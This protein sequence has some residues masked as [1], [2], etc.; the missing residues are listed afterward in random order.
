MTKTWYDGKHHGTAVI[1]KPWGAPAS[2]PISPSL[3]PCCPLCM[4]TKT[5][6]GP[7]KGIWECKIKAFCAYSELLMKAEQARLT[8]QPFFLMKSV[9][10]VRAHGMG[11]A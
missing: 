2:G 11:K 5:L 1:R 3:S 7:K 8:E 10:G 9:H 4:G 6:Y